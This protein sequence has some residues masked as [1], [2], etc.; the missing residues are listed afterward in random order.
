MKSARRLFFALWPPDAL[1]R[2]LADECAALVLASGGKP[3]PP[4]NFHVTLVFVG[5]Q[6]EERFDDI[7]A[8]GAATSASAFTL[9]FRHAESWSR[10]KVLVLPAAQTPVELAALVDRLRINLLDRQIHLRL[11][12]YRPH[13][14]LARK[15]P[16]VWSARA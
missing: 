4:L 12:E 9:G 1:R 15:L 13:L 5:E 2:R 8:A 16:R 3:T 7:V 11:E 6:P 10:S 14:T